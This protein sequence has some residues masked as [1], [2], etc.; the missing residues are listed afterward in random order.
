MKA[1]VECGQTNS[2]DRL[3]SLTTLLNRAEPLNCAKTCCD[4]ETLLPNARH[5]RNTAAGR[6]LMS[7]WFSV[8]YADAG[9]RL[10]ALVS[11]SVCLWQ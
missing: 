4:F 6:M 11:V 9:L 5:F 7:D 1:G 2:R 8:V 3:F 10:M